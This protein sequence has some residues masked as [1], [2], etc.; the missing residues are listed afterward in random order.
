MSLPTARDT[1][2]TLQSSLQAKAKAEPAY[3]FYSLWDKVCR[4]D[5]LAEAYAR[6]RAHDGAPGSDGESCEAIEAQGREAWLE[7]LRTELRDKTYAPRPL[8]RVWIPK[9]HGGQRPL[10]IPILYAYCTSLQAAWGWN[11]AQRRELRL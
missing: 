1:V 4:A 5:V 3:R 10:G 2:R 8:L 9:S 6:C 7:R 11:R